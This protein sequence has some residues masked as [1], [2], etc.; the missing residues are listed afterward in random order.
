VPHW[1]DL[2]ENDLSLCWPVWMLT[3]G[4]YEAKDLWRVKIKSF[5]VVPKPRILD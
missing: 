2:I 4:A 3:N 1:V 5:G